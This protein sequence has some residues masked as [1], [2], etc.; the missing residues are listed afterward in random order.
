M[1]CMDDGLYNFGYSSMDWTVK[2]SEC[3]RGLYQDLHVHSYAF[4][5]IYLSVYK[6]YCIGRYKIEPVMDSEFICS[7]PT[8]LSTG[9]PINNLQCTRLHDKEIRWGSSELSGNF[10]H[11]T[12]IQKVPGSIPSWISVDFLSSNMRHYK[13]TLCQQLVLP[14]TAHISHSYF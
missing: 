9:D 5:I 10:E 14:K 1:D 8:T 7:R 11:S 3:W 2:N 12:K 4:V 6:A 13:A